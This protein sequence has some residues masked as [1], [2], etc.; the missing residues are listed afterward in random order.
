MC[1]CVCF[2]AHEG[3]QWAHVFAREREHVWASH[4]W[5]QGGED[6]WWAAG[7]LPKLAATPSP[8]PAHP[9]FCVLWQ[10]FPGLGALRVQA[11]AALSLL[12]LP[13]FALLTLAASLL[14]TLPDLLS[15]CLS[16]SFTAPARPFWKTQPSCCPGAQPGP[17]GACS[18][19][20]AF[21]K[22]S[23]LNL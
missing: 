18:N 17:V 12:P 1:E 14:P 15:L 23:L 22:S 19:W 20:E 10:G 6:C 11:R 2:C 3:C 7:G 4:C 16:L 13:G 8:A 9:G 21:G 5:E